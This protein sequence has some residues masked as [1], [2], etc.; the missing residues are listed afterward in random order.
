MDLS[1]AATL[2]PKRSITTKVSYHQLSSIILSQVFHRP[3]TPGEALHSLFLLA[4]LFSVFTYV[5]ICSF[6]GA[7][8]RLL[9]FDAFCHCFVPTVTLYFVRRHF[10]SKRIIDFLLA[11]LGVHGP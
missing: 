2:D 1:H 3:Q 11:V 9:L 8:L 5:F 10:L 7:G 4:C 6:F